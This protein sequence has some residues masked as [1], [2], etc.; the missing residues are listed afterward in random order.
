MLLR[1]RGQG[2]E[3]FGGARQEA[4]EVPQLGAPS[5]EGAV[6]PLQRR[7]PPHAVAW[8]PPGRSRSSLPPGPLPRYPARYRPAVPTRR[9][10]CAGRRRQSVPARIWRLRPQRAAGC[11]CR[12]RH[13]RR[14]PKS[15]GRG[16]HE[17]RGGAAE[18]GGR[19]RSGGLPRVL[20]RGHWRASAGGARA[21]QPRGGA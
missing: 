1:P 16:T 18:G 10:S 20:G 9:P 19:T 2:L 15:F 8:R 5:A 6:A 21:S 11:R 4:D 17:G 13:G 12:A 14:N 3:R 7:A